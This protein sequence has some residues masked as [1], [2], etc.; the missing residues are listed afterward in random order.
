M[1]NT[2]FLAVNQQELDT[3]YSVIDDIDYNI[4]DQYTVSN[5]GTFILAASGTTYIPFGQ[6][7]AAT[8]ARIKSDQPLTLKINGSTTPI[9]SIYDYISK[10]IYV[11]LQVTNESSTDNA[12]I[13]F[14]LYGTEDLYSTPSELMALLGSESFG[15]VSVKSYGAK[16]DGVTD[17]TAAIQAAIDA[18]VNGCVLYFPT[19]TYMI[20][21]LDFSS[22]NIVFVGGQ[23]AILK[24]SAIIGEFTYITADNLTFNNLIFD[25]NLKAKTAIWV[26]VSHEN[27]KF[28]NCQILNCYDNGAASPVRGILIKGNCSNIRITDCIFNTMTATPNGVTGDNGGTSRAIEITPNI[29][30]GETYSTDIIISNCTIKNVTPRE[31]GDAI[32]ISGG[33]NLDENA[34]VIVE[35]CYFE[36]CAK[37]A[38]KIMCCGVTVKDC[39]VINNYAGTD[40]VNYLDSMENAIAIY[41]SNVNIV[42]NSF[43]GGPYADVISLNTTYTVNNILISDNIITGTLGKALPYYGA[44]ALMSSDSTNIIV[45]NNIINL[46][47]NGVYVRKKLEDSLIHGNLISDVTNGINFNDYTSTSIKNIIVSNNI[48][49][50]TTYGIRV[51]FGTDYIFDNNNITS[52]SSKMIWNTTKSEYLTTYATY[53]P[54]SLN[55]GEGVTTTVTLATAALGD[56]VV[57]SFDKDLQGITLT[58]YVSAVNTVSI[59]FQNETGGTLD[60]A[61]GTLKVKLIKT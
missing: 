28:N 35:N 13:D 38:V 16:G 25:A 36:N 22:D 26:D 57:A 20:T 51:D 40:T 10:G 49:N 17:D 61:S 56:L 18:M 45:R 11:G 47:S 32:V 53:D 37:R 58:A 9:Y 8:N 60:L 59:R 39:S 46:S 43:I 7:A 4:E 44:I 15:I 23:N 27:L 24:C 5:K 14:E 19:G 50:A 52:G 33:L 3:D 55:D 54:I 29:S 42:G 12:T 31:D 6:L 2:L 1:S 30:I 48:L 21:Q 34:S 41:A